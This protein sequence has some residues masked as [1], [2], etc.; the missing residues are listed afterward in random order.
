[1]VI[2]EKLDGMNACIVIEEHDWN[3]LDDPWTIAV[4][5]FRDEVEWFGGA[6]EDRPTWED[7]HLSKVIA[8]VNLSSQEGSETVT[9]QHWIGAQS[10]T[11]LVIPEDDNHGFARWVSDNAASLVGDLGPGRHFGEWWGRGINRN[12][13]LDHR[14]F[15]LF[16][17]EK[18]TARRP[19][20]HTDQLDVVPVIQP[21]DTGGWSESWSHLAL[22]AAGRL[23]DHGS[24]AAPGFRNPEGVCVYHPASRQ[25]FKYTLDG[26]GHKG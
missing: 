4:R 21:Y 15:S 23:K 10:R 5:D 8:V 18:W 24:F 13:G 22:N 6:Y 16:N 3:Y 25:V 11:R 19:F 1:V 9:K 26:D 12:Y 20:F 2:T 14:R 17:T 7:S